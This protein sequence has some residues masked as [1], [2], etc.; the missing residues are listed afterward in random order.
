MNLKSFIRNF[1]LKETQNI[2]KGEHEAPSRH[3][4]EASCPLWDM[5]PMFGEDIYS[6]NA[7]KYFGDGLP[8]DS[9]AI[10]IIQAYRNKP[11]SFLTIYR[12][13]PD[14]DFEIKEKIK[15]LVGLLNYH[16][17]F[18]FFPIASKRT[19]EQNRILDH[20]EDVEYKYIDNY[21]EKQQAIL[22]DLEKQVEDLSKQKNK[23]HLK[24]NDGDWITT[25]RE[26]AK[27][28]GNDNLNGKFKIISKKVRA[29]EVYS[30]GNSI[31][32][33]GYSPESSS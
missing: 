16:L 7:S 8:Y 21:D 26:Y 5:T 30:E 15:P 12:A 11:K 24:I 2:Y 17:T 22:K 3:D 4:G 23:N 29:S 6:M 33:F 18:G 13:V 27:E 9:Q 10:S 25:V 19:P 20:L 32:E 1:L 14:L 31:Y 28:H